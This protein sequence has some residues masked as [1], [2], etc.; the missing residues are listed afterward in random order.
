[1]LMVVREEFSRKYGL[2]DQRSA[3]PVVL[4]PVLTSPG[5]IGII[6]L[7][8]SCAAL[9]VIGWGLL[10]AG[11]LYVLAG[12]STAAWVLT[13]IGLAVTHVVAAAACWHYAVSLSETASRTRRDG[14]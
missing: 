7:V 5:E 4:E 1:M 2:R 8:A 10:L 11:V 6:L 12:Y 9:M 14:Q 3:A 13:A